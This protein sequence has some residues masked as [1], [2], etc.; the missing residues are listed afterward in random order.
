MEVS[1]LRYNEPMTYKVPLVLKEDV[2]IIS[3]GDS[4]EAVAIRSILESFN[5]RVTVHWIGSREEVIE[6]LKGNIKTDKTAIISCHGVEDGIV[7][8]DELSLGAQEIA[9]VAHLTGKIIINVGC[10]TG[11]PDFV[12]AFKNSGASAYIA[13]TDYPQ[14]KAA[15]GF[16]SNLFLLLTSKITLK[17]AVQRASSFDKETEQFKLFV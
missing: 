10:L 14:G 1:E 6:I 17:E 8:S 2:T 12:E 9:D 4:L 16:I 15:V 13:P 5:Y 11:L 7:I 3:I